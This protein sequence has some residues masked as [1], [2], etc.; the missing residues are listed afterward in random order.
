MT[1]LSQK[2]ILFVWISSL[3]QEA[4]L[5]SANEQWC[6]FLSLFSSIVYKA[7]RNHLRLKTFVWIEWKRRLTESTL[8]DF[9]T[10]FPDC[11]SR[12]FYY[13]TST[14]GRTQWNVASILIAYILLPSFVKN[15]WILFTSTPNSSMNA[16]TTLGLQNTST[17][18]ASW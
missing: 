2:L 6:W 5:V 17:S 10:K 7:V 8:G 1:V 15:I 11:A 4:S 9:I 16:V 12:Q 14:D 3:I 18:S 13:R